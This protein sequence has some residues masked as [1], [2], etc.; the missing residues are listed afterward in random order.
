MIR[1][2]QAAVEELRPRLDL[3]EDLAALGD[4]VRAGLHADALRRWGDA[5]PLLHSGGLRWTAAGLATVSVVT[6]TGVGL[7]A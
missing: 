6:L 4:A 5:Q 1:E 7:G 3:R 2:R